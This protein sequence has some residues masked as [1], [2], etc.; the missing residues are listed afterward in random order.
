MENQ[1]PLNNDPA[2]LKTGVVETEKDLN[3]QVATPE[4]NDPLS[5]PNG[6]KLHADGRAELTATGCY[7]DLAK[8]FSTRKKWGAYIQFQLFHPCIL[9][10][11]WRSC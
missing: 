4:I 6:F 8:S 11:F 2:K 1:T 3:N 7:K 9:E 10:V 5:N